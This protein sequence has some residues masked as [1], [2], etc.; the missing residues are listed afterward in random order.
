[1]TMENK[2][3]PEDEEFALAEA[4]KAKQYLC[5]VCNQDYLHC[6]CFDID[7]EHLMTY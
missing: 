5:N 2:M 4:T 6:K 3:T 1:M 7:Y